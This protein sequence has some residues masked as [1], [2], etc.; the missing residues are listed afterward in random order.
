MFKACQSMFRQGQAVTTPTRNDGGQRR[1]WALF[2]IIFKNARV[3]DGTAAPWFVADVA[4]KDGYIVKVGRIEGEAKQVIDAAGKYLSPGFID[5][6]SHSDT[7]LVE[8]PTADSKIMQGVTLEVIGQCGTSAAPRNMGLREQDESEITKMAEDGPKWTDMASYMEVLESQ[9]VSVNVAPLVGHGT[10]RRQVMGVEPRPATPEEAEQ[11]KIL[12]REAMEQ[13]A[14]GM[15]TGLIYVPGRYSETSE[16]IELA[17]V[18]AEYGGVYFT[19][20]R[21]ESAHL[22]EALAEAIEIGN[23]AGLPAQVSHFKAMREPNWGKVPE[24]IAMIER[25]REDGLDITADQYPYIASSTGLGSPLPA[26]AWTG[27]EGSERLRDPEERKKILE[28]LKARGYWDSIVIANLEHPDDQ[29]YIGESVE[30]V[31]RIQGIS[32]EEAALGLLER[33]RGVVQIV[34]FA[35]NEDNVRTIMKLPW[36][37]VGSDG[38]ALNVK[39]AKGKPHP[40]NYGTFV[41]ILGR[42]VRDHKVLRLEE[43]VRKMTSLPAM[44]LGLQD[45]GILKEG[46]RADLVL[47]DADAVVDN[48]T[49]TEPHQYASGIDYV[50]VNGVIVVEDGAHNGARPGAVLRR[51]D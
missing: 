51:R 22:L 33:N 34:N 37:M 35:M 38:S 16:V 10:V 49:F 2:D 44:R 27:G 48:A 12:V 21:N 24:A 5:T 11:M 46:M 30:A 6:H 26:S 7:P 3:L 41:R 9:G 45:R 32:S 4:V 15:S 25:A 19:H 18:V 8:N 40:R 43:A 1:K 39:T 17:K 13:G 31:G 47:F 14:F 28:Q 36:V 20:I 29:Q 50:V 42:Y 23:E